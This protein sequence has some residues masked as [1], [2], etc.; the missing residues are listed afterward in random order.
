MIHIKVLVNHRIGLNRV[1]EPNVMIRPSGSAK[2]SVIIKRKQFS[3][4]PV[5]KY[6]VVCQKF[7][8]V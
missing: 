5:N 7:I 8:V 4:N 1:M 2:A 6:S 3:P